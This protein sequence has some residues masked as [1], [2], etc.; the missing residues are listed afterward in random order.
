LTKQL[1]IFSGLGADERV[2]ERLDFSGFQVTFIQ[3]IRP[4]KEE[5]LTQYTTR[6][7]EQVTTTKPIFIGLSF[8][9]LVAVEAAKQ[10]DTE[11]LIIIASAKTKREIPFYYRLA[12]FV[13]LHRLLPTGLLKSSNLLTH[14]F[15]GAASAYEK[16]LLKQILDD[17]DPVFLHWAIDKVVRW[18]NRTELKNLFHIHGTSD[19]ILP[20]AFVRCHATIKKGGHFMTMNKVAEMN[21]ILQEQLTG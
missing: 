8:G 15:F 11:K 2:F 4:V 20:L 13:R 12:G 7:L 16:K 10:M 17:T 1:Y 3:W 9:G 21:R 14:W 5:S 19:R 6:L 18:K